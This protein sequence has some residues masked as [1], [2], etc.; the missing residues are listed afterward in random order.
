MSSLFKLKGARAPD[1]WKTL[2]KYNVDLYLCGEVH[3]ITCTLADGV[4][5]V[6][7]GSLFGY[8]TSSNYLVAQVTPARIALELKSIE[9]VL[10]GGHVPQTTGNQPRESV[11]IADDAKREGFRTVGTMTIDKTGGRPR[12]IE[13]T[14][15]FAEAYDGRKK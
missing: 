12:C 7:H 1:F 15:A 3:A 5:Q 11:R 4:W 14:G 9:T 6:A 8:N 10:G 2:A 13:K